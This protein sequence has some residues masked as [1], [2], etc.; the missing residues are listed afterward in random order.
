MNSKKLTGTIL[1][2]SLLTVMAGAAVAPALD[3]IQT[4]FSDTDP[5]YVQMVISMPALFIAFLGGLSFAP[6]RRRTGSGAA[7]LAPVCFLAGYLLLLTRGWVGTLLGSALVGFA[8]GLEVPYLISTASA[9]AGRA[10]ATT[11][12]PM[13]SI[14]LYLAQFCTPVLLS[15]VAAPSAFIT[16][17]A[18]AGVLVLWSFLVRK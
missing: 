12:V 6:L 10:A 16:A 4:H 3:V 9:R 1:S 18:A 5:V 17:A 7:F 11:V 15:A 2:L 8:N 13:L 14:A